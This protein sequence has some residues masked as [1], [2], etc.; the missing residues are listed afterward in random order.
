MRSKVLRGEMLIR[1]GEAIYSIQDKDNLGELLVRAEGARLINELG[2]TT[3][4]KDAFVPYH[5][6]AVGYET[7]LIDSGSVRVTLNHKTCVVEK[8]DIIQIRPYIHHGFRYLEEGTIWR[9][10]FHDL[11]MYN[12]VTDKETLR[13]FAPGLLEDETFRARRL[14]RLGTYYRE[15]PIAREVS[16]YDIPEIRPA[17][18]ALCEHEF[19]GLTLRLKVGRW[20]L[21]GVK[22]IW[23]LLPENGLT[24]EYGMPFAD[25]PLYIVMAGSIHVEAG[26]ESFDAVERD[27]VHIPPYLAHKITVTSEGTKIFAYNVQSQLLLLVEK[28]K[29]AAAKDSAFLE[30]WD[31]VQ[32]LMREHN[33]WLTR[34][35]RQG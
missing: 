11:D 23:E 7:F 3:Y 2:D 31:A 6:H 16:K 9:E 19:P 18:K 24:L 17:D 26:D 35:T 15:E 1:P 32:A 33:C 14:K 27:V 30:N 4:I 5:D 28:L 20:E 10:M 29:A 13:D 34:I 12:G 22:E 8:G 25:S 21:D